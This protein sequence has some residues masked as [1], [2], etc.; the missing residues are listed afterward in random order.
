MPSP[1]VKLFLYEACADF[2][3]VRMHRGP[4]VSDGTTCETLPLFTEERL[5]PA[6]AW[7]LLVAAAPEST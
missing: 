3:P 6:E 5:A 2:P 7:Q 4:R 1:S